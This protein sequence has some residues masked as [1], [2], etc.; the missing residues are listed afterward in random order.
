M[1][2]STRQKVL[3]TGIVVMMMILIFQVYKI[4][5]KKAHTTQ[6]AI[7]STAVEPVKRPSLVPIQ[8]EVNPS[9]KAYLKLVNQYQLTEMTRLLA[10]QDAAIARARQTAAQSNSQVSKLSSADSNESV[11]NTDNGYQL[12]S[13]ILQH[14][15]WSAVLVKG[16]HYFTV[17]QGDMLPDGERVTAIH[18]KQIELSRAHKTRILYFVIS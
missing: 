17:S 14:N 15:T 12:R 13:V 8:K 3:I 10:E 1:N 9:Q 7:A 18:Q 4:F 16:E 6:L 2:I 5:L 11:L